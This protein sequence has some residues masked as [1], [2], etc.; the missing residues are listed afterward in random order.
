MHL[1]IYCHLYEFLSYNAG[2]LEN[3]GTWLLDV[4]TNGFPIKTSSIDPVLL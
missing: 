2:L 4:E 3:I 1:A